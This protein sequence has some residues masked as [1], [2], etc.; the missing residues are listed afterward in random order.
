MNNG[1]LKTLGDLPGAEPRSRAESPGRSGTQVRGSFPPIWDSGGSIEIL[2][3]RIRRDPT[4]LNA[5]VHR[6]RYY[7]TLND[8]PGCYASLVD[9]LIALGPRGVDL[10]KRMISR[11]AHLLAPYL[12]SFLE[13]HLDVGISAR[14]PLP[15]VTSS[16]LTEAI[17]GTTELIETGSADSFLR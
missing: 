10:R 6:I 17:S 1:P 5:H 3:K 7:Q 14:T 9:L 11:S 15:V 16:I 4:D 12:R 2:E 13:H 8:A